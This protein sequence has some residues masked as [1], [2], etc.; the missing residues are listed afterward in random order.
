MLLDL[1]KEKE[2]KLPEIMAISKGIF[3]GNFKTIL[4]IILLVFFPINLIM[5]VLNMNYNEIGAGIN[6]DVL[7]KDMNLLMQFVVSYEYKMLMVYSVLISLVQ[8]LFIPLGSAAVA[9]FSKNTI[10][11]E[12]INYKMAIQSALEKGPSLLLSSFVYFILIGFGMLLLLPGIYF[13]I[14]YYFYSYAIILED[15][16]AFQSMGYSAKLFTGAFWK[17]SGMLCGL[18]IMNFALNYIF[19]L[20]FAFGLHNFAIN[21][22]VNMLMSVINAFF[23]IASAVLFLN[24]QY[25]M[26]NKTA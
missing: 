25:R 26:S 5:G 2:L 16:K 9:K 6:F 8:A 20:L 24:R 1:I 23:Y 3:A 22:L 10:C 18:F 19:T 21:V 15:K 17:I 7:M 13:W 4:Y 12:A 11:G 14:R